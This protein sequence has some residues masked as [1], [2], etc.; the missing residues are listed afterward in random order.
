MNDIGRV[1][2]INYSR[3]ERIIKDEEGIS[4]KE[5]EAISFLRLTLQGGAVPSDSGSEGR[6]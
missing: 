6:S 3:L 2:F 4:S 1:E 5:A